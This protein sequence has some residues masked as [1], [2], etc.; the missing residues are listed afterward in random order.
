MVTGLKTTAG[1][2]A[3]LVL[4]LVTSAPGS[5]YPLHVDAG[6]PPDVP[7]STRVLAEQSGVDAAQLQARANAAG[8]PARAVLLRDGL[9]QPH[10]ATATRG[11]YLDV[12]VT[13]YTLQG[14]MAN[15][16]T[17][18][19]GAAACSSDIPMGSVIR[20]VDGVQVACE[21][22]GDLGSS[23]HV[24]VWGD[25]DAPHRYGERTR[26]T[27][28]PQGARLPELINQPLQ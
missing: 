12:R 5:A 2:A 22:T 6:E 23:G 18:H 25:A 28:V 26:V 3:A 9:L 14:R 15:G 4:A 24:D 11:Y 7:A 17:A 13:Y 10:M 8:Q 20:F 21:D 16:R 19:W 27:I 1:A